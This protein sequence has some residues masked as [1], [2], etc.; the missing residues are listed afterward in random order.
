MRPVPLAW[1]LLCS[2]VIEA[3]LHHKERMAADLLAFHSFTPS[4][5]SAYSPIH[6]LWGV[7]RRQVSTIGGATPHLVSMSHQRYVAWA[8][9]YMYCMRGYEQWLRASLASVED[10]YNVSFRRTARVTGTMWHNVLL[11]HARA[12]WDE[13]ASSRCAYFWKS[14]SAH[15]ARHVDRR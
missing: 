2:S 12:L 14:C 1:S 6:M 4:Y 8:T 11:F 15:T 7:Y 9:M 3:T 10:L 5:T 13:A